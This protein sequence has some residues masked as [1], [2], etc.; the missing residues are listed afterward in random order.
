MYCVLNKQGDIAI[1]VLG[2]FFILTH[3]VQRLWPCSP[4][5]WYSCI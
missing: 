3:P 5:S 2:H 1:F 4:P